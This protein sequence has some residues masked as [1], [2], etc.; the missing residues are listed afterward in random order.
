MK[1]SSTYEAG[2]HMRLSTTYEG[3][4]RDS[5]K[6]KNEASLLRDLHFLHYMRLLKCCCCFCIRE[7]SSA[8]SINPDD[9]KKVIKVLLSYDSVH[10]T[11]K[12]L[13][14]PGQ[15]EG[16]EPTVRFEPQSV[17]DMPLV[18]LLVCFIDQISLHTKS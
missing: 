3:Y 1:L 7:N 15:L 18:A 8:L 13:G 12:I 16:F 5:E 17:L 4:I 10:S 14:I 9:R 2:T 6:I 11:D